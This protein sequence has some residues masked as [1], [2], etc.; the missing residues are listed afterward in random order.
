M[1]YQQTL[2]LVALLLCTTHVTCQCTNETF[3]V[4]GAGIAGLGAANFLR[5]RNCSV[6]VLEARNRIGGR[7]STEVM[8]TTGGGIKVDMGASW[9]HGI[10]PGAGELE[11]FK[12]MENPIYTIA[13]ENKIATVQTWA[14][15]ELVEEKSYWWKSPATTLSQTRVSTM[16]DGVLKHV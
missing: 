14:D 2:A 13:K 10:G 1:L 5:Q 4:I 6:T 8:G 16:A 7:L 12:N 3:L 15:E 11:E 9:I